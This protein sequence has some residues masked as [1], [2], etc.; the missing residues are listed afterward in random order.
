MHNEMTQKILKYIAFGLM[1]LAINA[2]NIQP[3]VQ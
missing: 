3:L 2:C 1:I